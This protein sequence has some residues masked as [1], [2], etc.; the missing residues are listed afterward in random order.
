MKPPKGDLV[1]LTNG[2]LVQINRWGGKHLS[3]TKM[4]GGWRGQASHP[5]A[6]WWVA[7]VPS[8]MSMGMGAATGCRRPG[9]DGGWSRSVMYCQ[10]RT[11]AF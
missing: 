11:G 6:R 7:G 8:D 10:D 9:L 5:H 2:L 4:A 1:G 3:E